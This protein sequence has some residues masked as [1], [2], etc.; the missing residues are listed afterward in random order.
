MPNTIVVTGC[1]AAHFDLAGELLASVAQAAPQRAFAVGFVHVGGEALPPQIA[2]AVDHI[3]AIADEAY[4]VEGRQGFRLAHLA[5]KARLPELF[6]GFDTYVWLDGDTWVQNAAGVD[7][8]AGCAARAD[9][10]LHPELDANYLAEPIP[11]QRSRW[12]YPELYGEEEARALIATPMVNGGVFA[13]RAAS[14]LWALWQGALAELRDQIAGKPDLFLSDQIPLHR[15]VAK[16]RLSVY[17]L[18]AVNNW[19]IHAARP[20]V[21]LRRKR[22]VAP[23]FP[24][25]EINIVHLTGT[26]KMVQYPLGESGTLTTFRYPAIRRLFGQQPR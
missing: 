25:E 4:V 14:P 19:M 21:D 13:A 9:I 11:S 17:P 8:V 10:A 23:T 1:D 12:L 2:R 26:T 18:R 20:A 24:H 16:G 6:P 15:L 7:Q 22:L 5:V 3:V